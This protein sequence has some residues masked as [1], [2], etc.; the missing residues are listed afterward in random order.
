MDQRRPGMVNA[1]CIPSESQSSVKVALGRP[2]ICRPRSVKCTSTQVALG[3]S[4][5]CQG[6]SHAGQSTAG[7][8]HTWFTASQLQEST[9]LGSRPVNC[10]S[11]PYLVHGQSTAGVH[12]TW[13]TASQL[14]E[15]T[16]LGSRPVNCRSQPYLV[17]GQS[18]AGVN[19]TWFTASQP[20]LVHGLSRA[21]HFA[22]Q[23]RPKQV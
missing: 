19:H 7:V 3:Q 17:H 16:I 4:S 8:N 23:A 5:A 2:V 21:G 1:K 11:Q 22:R 12:H 10:R 20:Y 18:T 13:F 9:I 15:S 6:W 14:Q